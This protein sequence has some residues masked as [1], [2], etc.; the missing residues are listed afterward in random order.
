MCT[1][2]CVF[3]RQLLW[4]LRELDGRGYP[5][6]LWEAL[7]VRWS[8]CFQ[9][10]QGVE[11][12]L[13]IT[14]NPIQIGRSGWYISFPIFREECC[15]ARPLYAICPRCGMRAEVVKFVWNWEEDE[16]E[17]LVQCRCG[18][19]MLP[20]LENRVIP[21]DLRNPYMHEENNHF[22]LLVPPGWNDD[23]WSQFVERLVR[24]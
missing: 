1:K 19:S 4:T 5:Q 6:P 7:C 2:K 10:L 23:M 18:R 3:G 14:E 11:F 12:L 13:W 17:A 20:Y 16:S 24:W 21:V 15:M 8:Q 22:D 9:G